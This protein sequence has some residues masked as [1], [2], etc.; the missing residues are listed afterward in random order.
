MTANRRWFDWHSWLGVTSGLL[1]FFICWTG[2]V[3]TI[4]NELDWLAAPSHWGAGEG[5]PLDY[6]RLQ[7]AAQAAA[8][9]AELSLIR[10]PLY[11]GAPAEVWVR[12]PN[13]QT[14]ILAIDAQTYE[15]R[16]D[17]SRITIQRFFRSI[18][19]NLFGLSGAGLIVV[20]LFVVPLLILLVSALTFYK[21]WWRK[22]IILQVKS[23]PR[24]FWSSAHK[25]VGL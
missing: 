25:V 5:G 16:S 21:R 22:F 8:P 3:A 18:H 23:G 24:A 12:T 14:R 20:T 10:T 6:A 4:S 9:N 17:T 13:E 19:M 2:S 11:P 1:L 15:V 7:S